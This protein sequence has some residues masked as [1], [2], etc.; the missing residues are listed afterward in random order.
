MSQRIFR[1]QESEHFREPV[2]GANS[3]TFLDGSYVAIN[4][5]GFL[6]VATAGLRLEGICRQNVNMASNNQTVAMVTPLV[7]D[8]DNVEMSMLADQAF[9]Q[10]NVGEYVAISTVTAGLQTLALSTSSAT[11]GALRVI[12]LLDTISGDPSWSGNT[13]QIVV[14]RAIAQD[15][16]YTPS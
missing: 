6:I 5:S 9:T 2:I 14:K 15:L 4:S 12:G 13:T 16:A 7:I 10:T 3:E 1:E 8:A 11:Q